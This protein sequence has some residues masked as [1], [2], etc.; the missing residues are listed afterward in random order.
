MEL[1]ASPRLSSRREAGRRLAQRL[2]AYRA[3]PGALVAVIPR[4]GLPVGEEVAAALGLPLEALFCRKLRC[5]TD[6]ALA[7]GA[8]SEHDELFLNPAV[9]GA[10]RLCGASLDAELRRARAALGELRK[11]LRPGR[12]FPDPGGRVVLV[13][14][15]GAE[16]G[17]TLSA[18]L[19][20]LRAGRPARLVAAVPVAARAIAA[21]L[22]RRADELVVLERPDDLRSLKAYYGDAPG[23]PR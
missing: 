13:V 9:P 6:P 16:T 18:A 21:D 12:A 2:L 14:D 10:E 8:L 3:A 15:D 19:Q 5:P 4:A 11:R 20:A 17:A 7:V 22:A 23:T 1:G